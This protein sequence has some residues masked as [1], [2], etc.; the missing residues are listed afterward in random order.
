MA[1]VDTVYMGTGFRSNSR[2][3]F[4]EY[5]LYLE[6]R[7]GKCNSACTG[8][9]FDR[10][11]CGQWQEVCDLCLIVFARNVSQK[12]LHANTCAAPM[13]DTPTK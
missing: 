10:E 2:P 4:V 1:G 12:S 8:A 11:V 13:H 9:R 5:I 6:Q 3:I 7:W